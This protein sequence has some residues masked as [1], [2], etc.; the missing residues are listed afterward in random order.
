MALIDRIQRK[1]V[2]AAAF[3]DIDPHL[4]SFVSL[5]TPEAYHAALIK[6]ET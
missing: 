2:D 6:L 3:R 1:R 5:D 4:E